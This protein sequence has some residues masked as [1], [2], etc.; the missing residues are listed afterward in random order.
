VTF[1][2]SRNYN[3][4]FDQNPTVHVEY[5]WLAGDCF[6]MASCLVRKL[7]DRAVRVAVTRGQPQQQQQH[8]DGPAQQNPHFHH[9]N[10]QWLH[11]RHKRLSAGMDYHHYLQF[12]LLQVSR[13]SR[14]HHCR[15]LRIPMGY[16]NDTSQ[17]PKSVSESGLGGFLWEIDHTTE[18]GIVD[19]DA[20][21]DCA[22]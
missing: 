21:F 7:L 17:K 19:F 22:V 13:S 2:F 5:P 10:R 3:W 14:K 20:P 18:Y 1:P 9:H 8:G 16:L 11:H 12:K 15:D 4:D 6:F